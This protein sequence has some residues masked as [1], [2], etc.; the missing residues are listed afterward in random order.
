[1]PERRP[2]PT[3]ARE[4][5]GVTRSLAWSLV[6]RLL[7]AVLLLVLID[8]AATWL[9]THRVGRAQWEL[10][11]IIYA[12]VAGQLVLLALLV[13]AVVSG[14]RAGLRAVV[15][16]SEQIE[17]R[18]IDDLSAIAGA[19]VPTEMLP[20][21]AQTNALL[22]RLE[23]SVAA[24]RRFI[25][26]AA[27]QLRT[28]LAGLKVESELMLAHPAP[29]DVHQRAERIKQA[30]DRMIRMGQQMLL[31]ARADPSARPRDRFAR[32]DLGELAQESGAACFPAVRRAG[33]TLELVAPPGPVW[34]DGDPVLLTELVTNLIDN[35]VRYGGT[36]GG[37]IVLRVT[38][39]PPALAVEDDGPGIDPA[40]RKRV[41][42]PFYRAA[43]AP[44]GG[45]GLG[46]AI[47][48]EIARAHGAHW[49][50]QSRPDFAGTRVGLVF[51]GPRIGARLNRNGILPVSSAAA[52]RDSAPAG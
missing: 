10:E 27:H 3:M 33:M 37:C 5:G 23:E 26:H 42:E 24:Q 36:A 13:L 38:D 50:L 40:E 43:D 21:V 15:R 30:T 46:L 19:G 16:V 29:P 22:A 4:E 14:V 44:P 41:F 51:P 17:Q 28:P 18:D 2:A 6:I 45:S 48:S 49:R 9:V 12:L 1:M 32:L 7:P 20:L 11:E 34:V 47:V 8:A 52:G 25:G 35:A 39:A 31:M